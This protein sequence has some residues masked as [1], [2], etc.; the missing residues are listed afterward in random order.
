[1][2]CSILSEKSPTKGLWFL[3][4]FRLQSLNSIT[5]QLTTTLD[6]ILLQLLPFPS[7]ILSI[8]YIYFLSFLNFLNYIIMPN[9][10]NDSNSTLASTGS[11]DQVVVPN[12]QGTLV[13]SHPA[14]HFLHA[15]RHS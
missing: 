15:N 14:T 4:V 5:T 8:Y 13:P 1:M 10:I 6:S 9:K 3:A 2:L 12:M 11:N 7:Y